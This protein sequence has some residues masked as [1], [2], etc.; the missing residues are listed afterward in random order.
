MS[1]CIIKKALNVSAFFVALIYV[2]GVLAFVPG[3]AYANCE[4]QQ[5]DDTATVL[6]VVDGDTLLLTDRRKVRL[7]GINTPE[8]A[9]YPKKQEPLALNAKQ[10]VESLLFL[11]KK[12]HLK[13]GR[14]Q[15]DR[16]GRILAHIFLN[17]GR[18][19]NAILLKKG[20]ASAI[21]VPPNLK[22]NECYF[23]L[24]QVA[25]EK[26]ERYPSTIWTHHYFKHLDSRKI[27]KSKKGFRFIKGKVMRI[28]RSRDSIWLQLASKFTIRIKRKD[29]KYFT[30]VNLEKLK[31]AQIKNKMIYIR[32]WVY[33][34][35]NAMYIQLR[36]PAMVNSG[37]FK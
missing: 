14:Q 35:K 17:D 16:Y 23:R 30:R 2:F 36:H 12:I 9:H 26:S 18:N 5:Y 22:F 27:D 28:G 34:W 11:N 15:K 31:L 7:I 4:T 33:E 3:S 19:L 6:R 21:V 29:F 20:L 37:V 24:E 10:L 25:K 8:L 32:G 1:V 13:Y